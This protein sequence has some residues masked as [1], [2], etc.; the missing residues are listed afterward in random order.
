[1]SRPRAEQ[2]L[3]SGKITEDIVDRQVFLALAQASHGM[4][5]ESGTRIA[6]LAYRCSP[7]P[8]KLRGGASRSRPVP[9]QAMQ[10][11]LSVVRSVSNMPSKVST[12]AYVTRLDRAVQVVVAWTEFSV[13]PE[14]LLRAMSLP[15]RCG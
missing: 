4:R 3:L 9:H 13:K 15:A 12:V 5:A 6:P 14:D 11:L 7:F 2:C 1:M 8:G 10:M